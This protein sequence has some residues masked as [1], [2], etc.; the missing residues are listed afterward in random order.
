V[1]GTGRERREARV[2]HPG[3]GLPSSGS[4]G[5]SALG[6]LGESCGVVPMSTQAELFP[7]EM[8]GLGELG[9]LRHARSAQIPPRSTS[10]LLA[11]NNLSAPACSQ[12]S[13]HQEPKL[14][15]EA[16]RALG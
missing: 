1:E 16:H 14:P 6:E 15:A 7:L 10:A 5:C 9:K 12:D 8:V 4:R 3:V 13:E 2:E 11:P